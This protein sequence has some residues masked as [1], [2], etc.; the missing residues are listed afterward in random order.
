M[1]EIR[2]IAAEIN[3]GDKT[4]DEK[5]EDDDKE[6]MANISSNH[7]V[8]LESLKNLCD[9]FHLNSRN[10]GTFSHLSEIERVFKKICRNIKKKP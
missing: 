8:A 1:W 3:G 6:D 10:E 5:E 2:D 9:Y 7:T 4:K